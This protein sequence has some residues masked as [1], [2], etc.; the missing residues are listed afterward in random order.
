M[1]RLFSAGPLLERLQRHW[2]PFAVVV[3]AIIGVAVGAFDLGKGVER[4]LQDWRFAVRSHPASGQLVIVE[5]DA[6]SIATIDH[7]P[8]PRSNH[9]RLI[10]QL[11]RA[12]AATIAFDVDFS[13]RSN[14]AEDGALAAALA[15]ADGQVILPTF[16]QTAGTGRSENTDSLPPPYLRDHAL[17]AAVTIQ[18]D[19]DGTVRS[20]PFGTITAGLARPSLSAMIAGRAGV[21]GEQ[22]PIDYG[23]DPGTIPR[24]SFVEVRDGHFDVAAVRG[25]RVLVGATAIELGDRYAIPGHGVVPGVVIQALAAETLAVGVPRA[26]GWVGPLLVVMLLG[27]ALVRLAGRPRWIVTS[28]LVAVP[29][30]MFFAAV[31]CSSW[32]GWQ[33]ELVPAYAAWAMLGGIVLAVRATL[34]FQRD[35]MHDSASGL[36]NRAALIAARVQGMPAVAAARILDYD[37]IMA[38]LGP[39]AAGDVIRRVRDR[40]ALLDGAV[41]VYRV[42]DSVLAMPCDDDPDEFVRRYDQARVLML[43]PIEVQGRKVDVSLALGLA[44]VGDRDSAGAVANA[45]LAADQA[46]NSGTLWHVHAASEHEEASRDLS[47][48]SDLDAAVTS[49][50]LRVVYQPKLAIAEGRVAS[51]EALVRWMH[52]VRG[53]ISPDDFIPLAERN[54]RIARLTLFVLESTIA[55]L[56]VWDALGVRISGAVNISAYLLTAPSFLDDVR[57]L[58]RASGLAPRRLIFEITESAAMTDAQVAIAALHEFKA[59]GIGI[60]LDDYGTGQSTLSYLKKLPLDELKIDRSFVQFAHRNRSDGVLVRS[61]IELAHELGLKVVAEG[62]NDDECLAFLRAARCD[63]AQGYFISKPVDAAAIAHLLA[64]PRT[65]V[66]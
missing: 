61:T 11:R 20:A 34:S 4:G 57:A 39:D 32:F 42:A 35:R 37:R 30:A 54:G 44:S 48:L 17:L 13:S 7:W 3:A 31:G 36:P 5:I 14:P 10:D 41:T 12:G 52:P 38:G 59:M 29:T 60:S 18:P 63:L 45:V 47:L 25:K 2:R 26:G 49:G 51:V 19:R 40:L 1:I 64:Q 22:F 28:I 23:I 8:W 53:M 65:K 66:A 9:A 21:V 43:S 24:L 50:E 55:D 27:V 15:R 62:V 16:S 33:F 56:R 46:T 6:H 58:I